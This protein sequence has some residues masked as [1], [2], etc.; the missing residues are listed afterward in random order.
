MKNSM[1]EK[2]S[3]AHPTSCIAEHSGIGLS[4]EHPLEGTEGVNRERLFSDCLPYNILSSMFTSC[5][6]AQVTFLIY[7][8]AKVLPV[9]R[10]MKSL[11]SLMRQHI[12]S[13]AQE[14]LKRE[15]P[16]RCRV[17]QI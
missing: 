14:V 5:R 2:A 4:A 15:S 6:D 17:D 16:E 10:W 12:K 8:Q 7:L 1:H 3:F 9:D 13:G 11:T